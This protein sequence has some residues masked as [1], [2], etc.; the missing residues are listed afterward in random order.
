MRP[1]LKTLINAAASFWLCIV[2]LFLL[3]VL[4]FFGTIE[5]VEHGLYEV[6]QKYFN[7]LF[8]VHELPGGIP[9]PLPGAYLVMGLLSINLLLGAMCR[10]PKSW[11]RPGMLIVHGG[12]VYLVLAGFVT[13]HY[14]TSGHMSLYEGEES[15]HFESYTDWSITVTEVGENASGRRYSIAAVEFE[16][17]PPGKTRTFSAADLPFD[18]ELGRYMKNS[19][20]RLAEDGDTGAVDGVVL[21][22]IPA[23]ADDGMNFRGVYVSIVEKASDERHDGVLWGAS[24]IPWVATVGE[25]QYALQLAHDRYKVPFTI[26]LEGFIRDLYP[27]TSMPSNF[28]SRVTLTEDTIGREVEIKMNQ[29][30]RHRGYAFFQA[31]WGPEGAGPNTPLYSTFAVVKNPADQWPK[32]ACYVITVGLSIHFLTTLLRYL[33]TENRRRAHV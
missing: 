19:Q 27:G 2:L 28:E 10:T 4:T 20:P 8:L 26:A 18:V 3:L 23:E 7:S 11:K 29:P 12:I 1:V 32:Y 17:L 14:S 25:R 22:P 21:Q 15:S 6:Q 31:S 5:Q 33:Q 9:L 16:D 24:R 30:L 13:F